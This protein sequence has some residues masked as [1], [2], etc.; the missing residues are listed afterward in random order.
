VL[1]EKNKVGKILFLEIAEEEK[2]NWNRE[3]DV[4]EV[5]IQE[6]LEFPSIR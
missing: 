4:R 1:F 6:Q 5:T 3:A 2:A